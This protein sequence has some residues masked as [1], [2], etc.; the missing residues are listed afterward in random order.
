MMYIIW[1]QLKLLEKNLKDNFK[2][3]KLA[4][5]K[6]ASK[7]KKKLKWQHQIHRRTICSV[8]VTI[9]SCVSHSSCSRAILSTGE[10]AQYTKIKFIVD[11]GG[12]SFIRICRTC[13]SGGLLQAELCLSHSQRIISL[14]Q[15]CLERTRVIAVQTPPCCSLVK[16]QNISS[17][18]L[19]C[20]RPPI[21]LLG[22]HDI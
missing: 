5:M 11:P 21:S 3:T 12:V 2:L 6:S 17:T 18:N 15:A 20:F 9:A 7:T 19:S 13:L 1:F 10:R 16:Q 8:L 4:A 22:P 14:G